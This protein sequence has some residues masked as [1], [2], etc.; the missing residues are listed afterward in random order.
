MAAQRP[1]RS[2]EII[3]FPSPPIV[4]SVF[5]AKDRLELMHWEA[6]GNGSIR[7]SI[8]KRQDG[9]PPDIGEFASIYPLDG[10]WAA[11]GA[12][13][14]GRNISVWRTRDGQDVGRF[15]SMT[16][17]L[18]LLAGYTLRTRQSG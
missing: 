14:Q 16:E 8:Y 1:R 13:R 11:W 3:P 4:A 12:V 17:V 6:Q 5:T 7:L 10:S 18:A 2:A 15:E 9:D